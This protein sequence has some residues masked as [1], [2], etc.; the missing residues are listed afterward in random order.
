MSTKTSLIQLVY[1][2]AATHLFSE[3]ELAE[4]LACARK[5]N[6]ALSITGM[7]VYSEG[8]FMQV[9]EGAETA[10]D[11]LF[12]K[13]GTD[14]R[15]GHVI[16]LMRNAISARSFGAWTMG[17]AN[18]S[19]VD[20]LNLPGCNDFFAGGACLGDV[21]PGRARTILEFFRQAN[22]QSGMGQVRIA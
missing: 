21:D 5:N 4:V 12:N 22:M 19:R 6:A 17:F 20:L 18:A 16:R 13:I 15:H 9:L 10:V 1:V 14:E 11:E 7:L 3:Q 8:S 2:S